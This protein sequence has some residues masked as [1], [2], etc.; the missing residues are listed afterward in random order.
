[1]LNKSPKINLA[2]CFIVITFFI[3]SNFSFH[4]Y[5]EYP[6]SYKEICSSNTENENEHDCEEHCIKD[7]YLK[8]TDIYNFVDF[9]VEDCFRNSDF[10]STK[11]VFVE[12]K[13]NSPPILIPYL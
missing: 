8:S 5:N 10:Y 1:M 7:R 3:S 9:S 4:F 2:V 12:E 13:S 6:Q 11:V